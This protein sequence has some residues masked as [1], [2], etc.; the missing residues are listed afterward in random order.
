[1]ELN[2]FNMLTNS[3]FVSLYFNSS[4]EMSQMLKKSGRRKRRSS[5][6]PPA[7]LSLSSIIQVTTMVPNST[8]RM[9][10]SYLVCKMSQ[11]RSRSPVTKARATR[12][13][14]QSQ[15]HPVAHSSTPRSARPLL[16]SVPSQFSILNL[17]LG[18]ASTR[19]SL[20]WNAT[21]TRAAT[22]PPQVTSTWMDT[23]TLRAETTAEARGRITN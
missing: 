9:Q 11:W 21:N 23:V 3:C 14:A 2:V 12:R 8:A 7:L 13:P 10:G 6:R 16:Y 17:L 15:T 19:P 22:A 4:L 18:R 1:M 5:R 20:L